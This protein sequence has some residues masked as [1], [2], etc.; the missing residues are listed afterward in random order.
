VEG[1]TLAER[2]AQG[3]IPVGEAISLFIQI[4]E[5]LARKIHKKIEKQK[6]LCDKNVVTQAFTS[7]KEAFAWPKIPQH[8]V[9][10]F[11]NFSLKKSWFSS[12]EIV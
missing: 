2:I 9:G 4:A 12:T 10:C 3:P 6:P 11:L 5:G 1:E 8:S 7:Q